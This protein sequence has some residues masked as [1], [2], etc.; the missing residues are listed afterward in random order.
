MILCVYTR[1]VQHYPVCTI[2]VDILTEACNRCLKSCASGLGIFQPV[3]PHAHPSCLRCLEMRRARIVLLFDCRFHLVSTR[4]SAFLY[5]YDLYATLYEI[6]EGGVKSAIYSKN[7]PFA[8]ANNFTPPL[9]HND[10]HPF[11]MQKVELSH[12]TCISLCIPP[13]MPAHPPNLISCPMETYK[14]NKICIFRCS[15]GVK[16][17]ILLR[18]FSITPSNYR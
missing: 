10:H 3:L 14:A 8:I 16:K 11:V 4:N 1:L 15:D 2:Q 18:N 17:S 5:G 6:L 13:Y 7:L 12:F 9:F